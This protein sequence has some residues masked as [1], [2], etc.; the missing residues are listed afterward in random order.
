MCVRE[1][2]KEGE[3]KRQSENKDN[4]CEEKEYIAF[5]NK[6]DRQIKAVKQRDKYIN[7]HTHLTQRHMNTKSTRHLEN[8]QAQR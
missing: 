6:Q 3:G 2:E 8:G 7:T 5:R 4:L 1:R